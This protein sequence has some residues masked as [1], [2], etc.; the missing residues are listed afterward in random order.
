[1]ALKLDIQIGCLGLLGS[2]RPSKVSARHAV[3]RAWRQNL[4]CSAQF[5]HAILL[6]VCRTCPFAVKST[7]ELEAKTHTHTQ[8]QRYQYKSVF[9]RTCSS[10]PCGM[11]TP[12][13]PKLKIIPLATACCRF[14]VPTVLDPP[15]QIYNC[16]NSPHSNSASFRNNSLTGPLFRCCR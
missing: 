6:R 11:P 1:M 7:L 5:F 9:V 3:F 4:E 15:L 12:N 8:T 13:H 2:T 16:C 14:A 10:C